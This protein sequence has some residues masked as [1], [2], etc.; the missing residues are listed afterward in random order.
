MTLCATAEILRGSDRMR[1]CLR[2]FL[3]TTLGGQAGAQN[4]TL[5]DRRDS[6][7]LKSHE[8]MLRPFLCTTLGGQAG[9]RMTLCSTAEILR[10]S[11][12]YES[13]LLGLFLYDFH[14]AGRG[15][16]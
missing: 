13:M 7:R 8:A 12:R 2:P 10:D 11:S 9:L 6:S 3:C 4:D 1:R 16:E 5:R 15:S 14:P